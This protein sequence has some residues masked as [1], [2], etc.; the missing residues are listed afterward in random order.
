MAKLTGNTLEGC[1]RQIAEGK[2]AEGDVAKIVSRTTARTDDDFEKVVQAYEKLGWRRLP[3]AREIAW[4]LWRA[5]KIDQPLL[6]GQNPL[7]GGAAWT[8]ETSANARSA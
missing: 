2:V 1:I 5:G 3:H 7:P 4:R 8:Q 6:R